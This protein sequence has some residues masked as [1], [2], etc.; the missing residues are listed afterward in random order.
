MGKQGRKQ[1]AEFNSG[2]HERRTVGLLL[3]D[4]YMDTV[5][6]GSSQLGNN[7]FLDKKK[8]CF[9]PKCSRLSNLKMDRTIQRVGC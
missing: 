6:L 8:S 3:G 9:Y 5:G 2:F 1:E 4:V 7:P